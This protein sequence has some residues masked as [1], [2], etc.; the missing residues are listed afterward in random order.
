M[1]K[2]RIFTTTSTKER[3]QVLAGLRRIVLS[4]KEAYKN[5]QAGLK[6]LKVK[7]KKI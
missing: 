4:A 7:K 3:K 1:A 2:R 6:Q 5:M